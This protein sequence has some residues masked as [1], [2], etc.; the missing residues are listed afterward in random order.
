[1]PGDAVYRDRRPVWCAFGISLALVAVYAIGYGTRLGWLGLGFIGLA[2]LLVSMW[3]E[4][5][6]D[7]P[8]S[9]HGLR[10][11]E[12]N[13]VARKM[14]GRFRASPEERLALAAA[15]EKRRRILKLVRGIGPVLTIVGF[16][17]FV[18]QQS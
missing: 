16:E 8:V 5:A 7:H 15:W 10:S 9:L 14:T 18:E 4:L 1:M 6:S 11:A 17:L 13:L 12:L 2:V 3:V